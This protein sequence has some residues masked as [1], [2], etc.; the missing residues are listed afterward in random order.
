MG[1][2]NRLN[3]LDR[4]LFARAVNARS[5]LG[6]RVLFSV[7]H[8]ANRSA[9]WLCVAAGL[10]AFG[11]RFGKRAALRGVL[12]IAMTSTVANLPF[13][14]LARRARP[15]LKAYLM[16][17]IVRPIPTSFSFPSGHSASAAAFA[18]GVGL[19]LPKA[20]L[21]LAA[22]AAAVGYSRVYT[23]AHY[24]GDVVAGA[25]LGVALGV[26][27]TRFWPVAPRT[28]AVAKPPLANVDRDPVPDGEGV[29]IVVNPSA[30]AAL[31]PDP[32]EEL[33]RALPK[34]SVVHLEDGTDYLKTV[35]D[36][37]RG[38][39]VL[40]IAGGDGS[41]NL[42]AGA[43]HEQG[44]PLLVVPS[45]TLNHFARDLGVNGVDDA[46]EAIR[47]GTTVTVDLGLV[48]GKPFVNT[49]S[50]GGYVQMVDARQRLEP[51]IGKWPAV[52]VALFRVLRTSEPVAVRVNGRNRLLWMAFIG[53]CR[54]KPSGFAPGWRERLDDGV[55][56]VRLVDAHEPWS[57]TRLMGAV[58]T[59]TLG[60]CRVYEQFASDKLEIESLQ[61]PLRLARDGETFEG[62]VK[63]EVTKSDRPLVVYVVKASR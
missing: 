36:L 4:A 11:G 19:E 47:G 26:A 18:T 43:A 62:P 41:V 54:Y 45:G 8:A 49:A 58:M 46:I 10:A 15:D 17:P 21:P 57:R 22:L 14:L 60:R 48:D 7:S 5:E 3:A 33:T 35:R 40:G 32:T 59:G 6:D 38:A 44:K 20:S 27:T 42:A 29:T 23:G 53:N 55:L 31:T 51:R 63:F 30:G 24:P 52:L 2:L 16:I 39:R 56:D 12:S 13:K 37:A 1:V 25:A 61:G 50:F 34:A 28:P 9:L